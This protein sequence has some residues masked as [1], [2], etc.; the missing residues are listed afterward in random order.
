[1]TQE[2]TPGSAVLQAAF[3]N[4]YDM[5]TLMR[6]DGSVL[7]V[8]PSVTQYLGF[9][10]KELVGSNAFELVHPDDIARLRQELAVALEQ[11]RGEVSAYRCRA[12]DGIWRWIKSTGALIGTEEEPRVVMFVSRDI[13]EQEESRNSLLKTN[14]EMRAIW[15]S[16]TDAFFA[17][18]S[19]WRIT[20]INSAGEQL[21][22]R[23]R[24]Q[25]IGQ[26]LWDKFPEAVDSDFFRQYHRAVHERIPVDFEEF[27]APL[28]T[29]FEVHAYPSSAGLAVYFRNINERKQAE[30][31]QLQAEEEQRRARQFLQSVLDALSAH[32]AVLNEHGEIVA[33]NA[34]WQRFAESNDA[35]AIA[36]GVGANYLEVCDDAEGLWASDAP[37]VAQAIRETIA[38]ERQAFSLEYPCHSAQDKRWFVL[39]ITRFNDEVPGRVVVA[40]EDITE[41]RKAR[42]EVR[43]SQQLYQAL[44]DNFPNGSVY[45]LDRDLKVTLA[46]GR[47]LEQLGLSA[48]SLIGKTTEEI[49]GNEQDYPEIDR[50]FQEALA[51]EVVNFE[52]EVR[53]FW[54]LVRTVPLIDENAFITGV[55]A[56]TQDITERKQSENALRES[57]ARLK[58]AQGLAHLGYVEV[59]VAT[60]NTC[61]SE[62]TFRILGLE[63]VL[64]ISEGPQQEYDFQNFL[65]YVHPDDAEKV[66]QAA[67]QLIEEGQPFQIEHRLLRPTGEVRWVQVKGEVILDENGRPKSF[68]AALLDITE[69]KGSEEAHVQ[70]AAI[71]KSSQDAISSMNRNGIIMTWNRGAE[72]LYGYSPEEAI[73]KH[74]DLITPS[75]ELQMLLDKAGHGESIQNFETRRR[76]K[77]GT[78]IDISLSLSPLVDASGQLLGSSVIARDITNRKRA[79]EALKHSEKLY[80]TLAHNFPNGSVFLVDRECRVILGAGRGLASAGLTSETVVGKT[81]RDIFRNEE[82]LCRRLDIAHEAALAG[83]ESVLEVDLRGQVRVVR[84]VPINSAAGE[85]TQVLTMTQDITDLKRAEEA[86]ARLAAIVEQSDDAIIGVDLSGRITTWNRGAEQLY[87]YSAGEVIGQHIGILVPEDRAHEEDQLLDLHKRGEKIGHFET[88]RLCKSG[89]A[90]SVSLASSPLIDAKGNIIGAS[91]IS[92]DIHEKKQAEAERERFFTLSFDLLCIFDSKGTFLRVNP[93]FEKTLGYLPEEL[94][95]NSF[96]DFIH[97][98]DVAGSLAGLT[99]LSQGNPVVGLVNRYRCSDGSFKSVL[100][101]TAPYG[102]MF[103]GTGRDITSIKQAENDLQQSV[104]LLNAT[105]ESTADGILVVNDEGRITHYNRNFGEMWGIPNSILESGDDRR[106]LTFVK[107]QLVDH[108]AFVISTR[109]SASAAD[110]DRSDL[111]H[112]KDG[113]VFERHARIQWLNGRDVGRVWSFRDVTERIRAFQ[114]QSALNEELEHQRRRLDDILTNVPG[115]VW[116]NAVDPETLEQ[117]VIYVSPYVEELLGYTQEEWMGT[118]QKWVQ[119]V[120]PLD[121]ERI[122]AESAAIMRSGRPGVLRYRCVTKDGR[123]IWTET[124]CAVT[125]DSGLRPVR[126]LGVTM[127]ISER[128]QA[129][130]EQ[131][132]LLALL[133]STTDMVGWTDTRGLVKYINPAGRVLLGLAPDEPI[134]GRKITE[135]SPEWAGQLLVEVGIPAAS[136]NGSWTGETALLSR[137]GREIP[138]S[139]VVTAHKDAGGGNLFFS[140]IGRDISESKRVQAFLE[141]AKEELEERVAQRTAE[142][143]EANYELKGEISERQMAV[144]ALREVVGLLEQARQEA[145]LAR[146]KAEVARLDAEMA[147]EQA[148]QANL[149]KSE[150]L[151]RMSHELRTPMNAILGFGQILEM[152][153]LGPRETESVNQILKAG[154]HLLQLI[155]EVLEISRIEAGEMSI[156]IEPVPLYEVITEALNL[157][158]PAAAQRGISLTIDESGSSLLVAETFINADRQRLRQVMLN[159]VSNAVKYNRDHGSVTIALK[160]VISGAE[161]HALAPTNAA[162]TNDESETRLRIE[163]RDTGQG[164]KLEDQTKLFVPFERLGAEGTAIEGTGIGLA[165]AKRLTELMHGQIGFE[166][167]LG[168]GSLFWVELPLAGD[169]NAQLRPSEEGEAGP[170]LQE[171]LISLSRPV[172]LLYIEDNASNLS[173]LE[174]VLGDI[175]EMSLLTAIQGRLGLELARQ[176][177]PDLI[178][179]DLHLPDIMGDEVLRELQEDRNCRDIPVVMLSADAT[180]KQ[181]ERLIGAGARE[182]LTKP[183]NIKQLLEV[184]RSFVS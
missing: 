90:V 71:V 123:F 143:A 154:Q 70:L 14:Q 177:H 2:F 178:L 174:S 37:I 109:E 100:W 180:E 119:S 138:I 39:R 160:K 172:T 10:P 19:Q 20:Y 4:S 107:E 45:L 89:E 23:S 78:T 144:G 64:P 83:R 126:L 47:G 48:A 74:T 130:E 165:L 159:L 88:I 115:I 167:T 55:M 124:N 127:D 58:Y 1:M 6:D 114:E 110:E 24:E 113:R 152:R 35:S 164:I 65:K 75:D 31:H 146:D 94:L 153:R 93:A 34:A 80:Q 18:D 173:L 85:I 66:T 184:I 52:V 141:R 77:D 128:M 81:P 38:G 116:E 7:F 150:F 26:D 147:R 53:G 51:G 59:N 176:H 33:V 106:A 157:V 22:Q 62:E 132:R 111:L 145:D 118:I 108:D 102:D 21:I 137:D 46:G 95:G 79:E 117:A 125:Y 168:Q 60:G 84:F 162:N 171:P 163:V 170:S 43:Y 68:A 56:M 8:S 156:S 97:P 134:E 28:Q 25:L 44:T 120:H 175:P 135:F 182:Y 76:R 57:E 151:S 148:E 61:W 13:T 5:V 32:V 30:L 91:Q 96:L 49:F 183:L 3:E 15:E 136:E 142:L 112:F 166:S 50:A 63:P 104:A 12:A 16:M 122:F 101:A 73:G 27:F 155:N 158:R 36:C 67:R 140:T 139:Q 105:L 11:T 41:V 169:P 17:V 40:H 161:L 9:A 121:R 42:E 92:R 69:R 54:R 181:I 29:W 82:E 149:A 72:Q 133:E 131:S 98:D 179:L 87:G 86:Q 103:Y 99:E 129:Q